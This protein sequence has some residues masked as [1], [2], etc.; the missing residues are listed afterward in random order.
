MLNVET[1]EVQALV[2]DPYY[3]NGAL[4]WDPSGTQLVFQRYPE[5]DSR[6]QRNLEGLPEIW[7]YNIETSE[8]TE[9]ATNAFKPQLIPQAEAQP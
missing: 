5:F 2:V 3:A 6:G 4:S 8:L 1:G 9:I 7:T